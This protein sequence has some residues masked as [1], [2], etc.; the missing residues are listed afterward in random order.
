MPNEKP[1]AVVILAAGVGKRLKSGL[2]K[3]CHNL[4]GEALIQHVLRTVEKLRPDSISVVV[5]HRKEQVI[6]KC[7]GFPVSIVEQEQLLGTAHATNVAIENLSIDSKVLILFGDVPLINISTL[8]KF[9]EK[10]RNYSVGVISAEVANPT[11][12]GRVIRD[13]SNNIYSI[14]EQKDA[15]KEQLKIQEVFTGILCI[16]SD[17]FKAWYPTL[18]NNNAQQEYYLPD[19]LS[20]AADHGQSIASFTLDDNFEIEGVNTRLQLATLERQFRINKALKFMEEGVS[21]IDFE[22]VYFR[23]EVRIGQDCTVDFNVLIDNSHINDNVTIGANCIIKNSTIEAGTVI[24]PNTYIDGAIIGKECTIG[25]FARI[26]PGTKLHANVKVGNF[27][28]IKKSEVNSN[29][30]I[31]HLSY[32]GDTLIMEEVNV[33]AGTVTCN[34]DGANKHKTKIEMNAFI[35]SGTQLVAPVTIGKNSTVGAGSTITKNVPDNKLAITRTQQQV[36]EFR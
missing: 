27:V 18:N 16:E 34:Y 11:G 14:V 4:A 33:G 30:K 32:V 28:E 22:R 12:Y 31:N 26:R 10:C 2:A 21:F 24:E 9:L 3:T 29:S 20:I 8:E 13:E 7:K 23:G 5:G 17:K 19:L 36:I 15:T 25:P 35:G 1:L 6:Q